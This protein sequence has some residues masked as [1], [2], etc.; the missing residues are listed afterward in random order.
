MVRRLEWPLPPLCR[1]EA[2]HAGGQQRCRGQRFFI[3]HRRQQARQARC[4]PRLAGA[5]R[6]HH[7]NM[8]AAGRCDFQRSPCS[9]LADHVGH[10][11]RRGYR[12]GGEFRCGD[13]HKPTIRRIS[14]MG[15][16]RGQVGCAVDVYARHKRCLRSAGRRQIQ[17]GGPMRA[18]GC[19]WPQHRKRDVRLGICRHPRHQIRSC[20]APR[21][22]RMTS[23]RSARHREGATHG[24]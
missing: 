11:H 9:T 10:V 3:G 19:G 5:W 18:L 14:Q 8:M 17:F 1:R 24:A 6:S 7:Q 21:V 2:R 22:C 23:R 13:R 4:Q 16:E 15:A 12:C 20:F